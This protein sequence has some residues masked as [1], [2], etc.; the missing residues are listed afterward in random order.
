MRPSRAK[1]GGP[2]WA[3][4]DLKQRR[5]LQ[6]CPPTDTD[7]LDPFPPIIQSPSPSPSPRSFSSILHP[8]SKHDIL[9]GVYCW[10]DESLIKD[11]MTSTND[12]FDKASAVLKDMV[13]T[14]SN[15]QINCQGSD[16]MDTSCIAAADVNEQHHDGDG[17]DND[18]SPMVV[19]S[20]DLSTGCVKLILSRFKSLP[21]EPE[22]AEE[23]ESDIY[24]KHRKH[25]LRIIRYVLC[26]ACCLPP[27]PVREIIVQS[28]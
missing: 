16:K 14:S 8:Y 12:D 24:L 28:T 7:T 22:S 6:Q 15:S 17:F 13:T 9:K 20:D 10:A 2:G 23:E 4:F 26:F 25:A 18:E 11:V 5:R 19:A 21:L 27:P 1:S 3:A